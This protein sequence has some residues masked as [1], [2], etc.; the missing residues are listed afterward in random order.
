MLSTISEAWGKLSPWI[1]TLCQSVVTKKPDAD[2]G[3]L[4]WIPDF[5]IRN[6][7]RKVPDSQEFK[8]IEV[9][10]KLL[11]SSWK[12]D[13]GCLSKSQIYSIPDP[14]VKTAPDLRSRIRI[15]NTIRSQ[16]WER[17]AFF[18]LDPRWF[19]SPGSRSISL[20]HR[21]NQIKLLPQLFQQMVPYRY[22]TLLVSSSLQLRN[23]E[24]NSDKKVKC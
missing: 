11:L 8:Y 12:Y 7:G 14:G 2:P 16:A 22:G 19:C 21:E 18:N 17:G 6:Q 24:K 10:Q 9:T 15:R 23:T 3:C 20:W 5:S 1:L 4:S 13:P